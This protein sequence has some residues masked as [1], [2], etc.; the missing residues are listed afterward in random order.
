MNVTTAKTAE[1]VAF[2]NAN[3]GKTAIKKFSDRATAEKRVAELIATLKP[4]K[5]ANGE[6]S[7]TAARGA[8]S[9]PVG[10]AERVAENRARK[11]TI[12]VPL[13]ETNKRGT[14]AERY[15]LYKNGMTVG[16][17][18]ELGGQLR[19]VAYDLRVGFISC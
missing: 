9:A 1:L 8:S 19:D 5:K 13:A 3:S 12:V 6:K 4:A 11:I 7:S 18:L 2:Y 10:Q 17:Y 16:K 15:A 14:A